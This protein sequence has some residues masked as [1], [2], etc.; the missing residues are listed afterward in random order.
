MTFVELPIRYRLSG[1][2]RVQT[3]NL[4]HV[5]AV[6]P[7]QA[8]GGGC[9]I[10]LVGDDAEGTVV[11]LPY[12]TVRDLLAQASGSPILRALAPAP[13][14]GGGLMLPDHERARAAH[15]AADAAHS[16]ERML[17]SVS[18]AL[19]RGETPDATTLM[20]IPATSDRLNALIALAG[21]VPTE[22]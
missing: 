3:V 14:E 21:I 2:L 19:R 20:F 16:L 15:E 18:H 11:A 22:R 12:E 7:F 17:L 13:A 1:A 4:A 6:W 9:F 5:V 8:D 10:S